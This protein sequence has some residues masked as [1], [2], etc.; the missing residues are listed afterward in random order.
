MWSCLSKI[1]YKNTCQNYLE[2]HFNGLYVFTLLFSWHLPQPYFH[3]LITFLT[4]YFHCEISEVSPLWSPTQLQ[5]VFGLTFQ[6]FHKRRFR[7]SSFQHNTEKQSKSNL[8]YEHTGAQ[9]ISLRKSLTNASLLWIQRW[10]WNIKLWPLNKSQQSCRDVL[11][12]STLL[13]WISMLTSFHQNL[14]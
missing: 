11:I 7:V 5:F 6:R 13:I 1:S 8:L 2:F 9:L 12:W 10:E 4:S 14:N 3:V